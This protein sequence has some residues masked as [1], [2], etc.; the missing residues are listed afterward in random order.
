MVKI[1]DLGRALLAEHLDR[2][3]TALLSERFPVL[4]EWRQGTR[5]LEGAESLPPI[6]VQVTP[7]EHMS[8]EES[9]AA[10]YRQIRESVEAD[11][12]SLARS[13]PPER[14]EKLVLD[15]LLRLGYGGAFGSGLHLGKG[16]DGGVDGV[17]QQD[18][19]GL[20]Q[21]Y[22]QAKRWR[23]NVGVTTVREFAGSL[24]AHHARKGVI[25]TTSSFTQEA[26]K[27]AGLMGD[28]IVLIDGVQLAAL[29][30]ETGLGVTVESAYELKRPDSDYFVDPGE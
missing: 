10:N 7:R 2:L 29:M 17:I 13:M 1:T 8:P 27:E 9:L 30:Y 25:I 19:L 24:S 22:V 14:F 15:L 16:G 28:R 6:S 3:D 5:H 23:D 4:R 20:E 11:V 26:R 21:I 12:L 18:K